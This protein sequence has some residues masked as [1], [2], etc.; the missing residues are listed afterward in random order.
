[1]V[2]ASGDLALGDPP[3]GTHG[4]RIE[5]AA[6]YPVHEPLILIAANVGVSTSGDTEQF[7]EIGGVRYSHIV[8]PKTALGLTTRVVVAAIAPCAALSDAWATACSVLSVTEPESMA[9]TLD[10]SV[11]VLVL[12]RDADGTLR[13]RS[14]G[15]RPPGLRTPL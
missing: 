5:I 7:V 8:D 15:T 2:A 10:E 13:R 6:G 12:R 3:P 14:Y 9:G 11:R 1:M 4:W